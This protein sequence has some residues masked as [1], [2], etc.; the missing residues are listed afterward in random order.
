MTP[1]LIVLLVLAGV[2]VLVASTALV[3]MLQRRDVLLRASEDATIDPS[4][5]VLRPE[6]AKQSRLQE[7]VEEWAKEPHNR[8]G[9]RNT[10]PVPPPAGRAA[11]G[12]GGAAWGS[13]GT[14]LP[15]L[16]GPRRW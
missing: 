5:I 8:G 14:A 2:A 1:L 9:G 11:R 10:N 6:K 13:R 4:A 16:V 3:S 7:R 12:A 15:R